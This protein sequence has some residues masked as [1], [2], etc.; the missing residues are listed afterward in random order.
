MIWINK[1][2]Y[3][4]CGKEYFTVDILDNSIS[5]LVS[6]DSPPP[7][8]RLL[9]SGELLLKQD[10]K[11]VLTDGLNAKESGLSVQVSPLNWT[12][13]PLD[14]VLH[15]P[16]ILSIQAEQLEV[17][18][19]FSWKLFQRLPLVQGSTVSGL[20][21]SSSS[22]S[23]T[24]SSGN[25]TTLNS[26]YGVR[27]FVPR[28]TALIGHE[29]SF[30]LVHSDKSVY[31]LV[32]PSYPMQAESL[33]SSGNIEEGIFLLEETCS[34]MREFPTLMKLI[35]Q[36][37]AW[38]R[39]KTGDWKRTV[40][41]FS[42]ANLPPS[43][44]IPSFP[45]LLL[46]ESQKT[47]DEDKLL[48]RIVE[49]LLQNSGRSSTKL[50]STDY[51]SEFER[52]IR[53]ACLYLTEY[54]ETLRERQML[55]RANPNPN[56]KGA[57]TLYDEP[58]TLQL[59]AAIFISKARYG[60]PAVGTSTIPS[61]RAVWAFLRS[62]NDY[63]L[64]LC[65]TSLE[66]WC[67]VQRYYVSLGLIY[68]L[69]KLNRK[70]LEEW[71]MVASKDKVGP[72][73]PSSAIEES[74]QLLQSLED[75]ELIEQFAPEIYKSSGNDASKLI[76][77][78]A[79]KSR[80]NGLLPLNWVEK[81]L[82]KFDKKLWEQYLEHVVFDLGISDEKTETT[83]AFLFLSLIPADQLAIL[84]CRPATSDAS[85]STSPSNS[86]TTQP[87]SLS[88]ERRKL[89]NLLEQKSNYNA[90]AILTRIDPLPLPQE[91]VS[92]YERLGDHEK[93]LAIIVNELEDFERAE[94]Y[95]M[96]HERE[97][98]DTLLA[99]LLRVYLSLD[100]QL[101]AKMEEGGGDDGQKLP[102]RALDLIERFPTRLR[103]GTVISSLPPETPICAIEDFLVQSIRAHL[104]SL[105]Q[106]AVTAGLERS[107]NMAVTAERMAL[108]QRSFLITADT[109]CPIC[110]R[111]IQPGMFARYPNNVLVHVPCMKNKN[112][113][114]LTGR[115]FY[116]NPQE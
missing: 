92:L 35:Q 83:L 23:L 70:A 41:H 88:N 78:L 90:A 56:P 96:K 86:D 25:S 67:T 38:T 20:N 97:G 55:Q 51:E 57:V 102:R 15:F 54:L 29:E 81:F 7:L 108:S 99:M 52:N 93:A 49:K 111:P 22:A 26:L 105:R 28:N 77:I 66:H 48:T 34:E 73:S 31:A 65:L 68:R 61:S 59:L 45:S 94:A 64:G 84:P 36:K 80:P 11:G 8:M 24:S 17:H 87:G 42:N 16:Y 13:T 116:K 72:E 85:S 32:A 109:T 89:L 40:V 103:P 112:I 71:S 110:T 63:E 18:S 30:V 19:T 113:D 82:E 50:S 4:T 12:T 58:T 62:L 115:N 104:A 106:T 5:P 95:C 74:I 107:H 114:P 44:I 14:L 2:I 98:Q 69:R 1:S 39:F 100:P 53:E 75:V 79:C 6:F 76:Q 101:R 43:H 37:A 60:L 46:I 21:S 3:V 27:S 47:T 91:K 10:R 33:V 9:H